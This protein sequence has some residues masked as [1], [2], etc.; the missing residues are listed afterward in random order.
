MKFTSGQEGLNG[1]RSMGRI[2]DPD[3]SQFK[4]V[5]AAKTDLKESMERYK[6]MVSGADQKLHNVQKAGDS[7]G[8]HGQVS[9][10]QDDSLQSTKLAVVRGKG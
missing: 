1:S 10:G 8:N 4:Y 7:R 5:P 9:S 6:R 3:W 2:L